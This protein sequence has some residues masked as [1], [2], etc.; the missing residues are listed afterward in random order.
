MSIASLPIRDKSQKGKNKA[1]IH[2]LMGISKMWYIH[3][4]KWYSAIKRNE[5]PINTQRGLIL[6]TLRCMKEGSHRRP[7]IVPFI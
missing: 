7:H 4:I 2:R 5:R 1:N 3:I 6:K